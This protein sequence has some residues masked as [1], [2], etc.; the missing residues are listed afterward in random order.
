VEVPNIFFRILSSSGRAQAKAI[1][2]GRLAMLH[3]MTDGELLALDRESLAEDVEI[4]GVRARVEVWGN[5]P[6]DPGR[7]FAVMLTSKGWRLLG[8]K[9]YSVLASDGFILENG[10]RTPMTSRDFWI[11]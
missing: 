2:E 11:Y 9:G 7:Y 8:M 10:V 3:A 5:P 1:V 4:E 6:S